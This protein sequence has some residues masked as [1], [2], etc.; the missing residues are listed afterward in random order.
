MFT[1]EQELLLATY[2]AEAFKR[3]RGL[4]LKAEDI[5]IEL[6]APYDRSIC[7]IW[8][9]TKRKDDNLRLLIIVRE[10][11][12]GGTSFGNFYFSQL[13]NYA[14][15]VLDD[16]YVSDVKL[17]RDEFL[18]FQRLTQSKKFVDDIVNADKKMYFA[19]G[20]EDFLVFENGTPV[21]FE[22]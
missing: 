10:F 9:N 20:S 13:Q 6:S 17:G 19:E 12:N 22:N 2:I 1:A 21:L 14:P 4:N 8:V 15:G 11:T 18:W 3:Q 5:E 7:T 16:V